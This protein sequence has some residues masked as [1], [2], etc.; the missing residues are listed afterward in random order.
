LLHDTTMKQRSRDRARDAGPRISL[1]TVAIAGLLA[2]G[3]S[4]GTGA[5]MPCANTV[6]AYCATNTCLM[7]WADVEARVCGAFGGEAVHTSA[8]ACKGF[9]SVDTF[10]VDS[11]ITYYYDATSGNLVA[12]FAYGN[13]SDSCVAGPT[14]FTQ[15]SCEGSGR[16]CLP[17]GGTD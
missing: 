6:A 5:S 3:C 10:G 13:G 2:G 14:T 4:G 12:V 16:P 17:D 11:G 1:A 7:T 9:N 15:P 8:Q